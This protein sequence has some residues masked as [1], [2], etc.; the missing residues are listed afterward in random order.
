MARLFAEYGADVIRLESPQHPDLLRQLGGPSGLSPSFVS[1]NHSKRSF[2][3]DLSDPRGVEIARDLARRADVVVENLAPG[4][5]ERFGIGVDVL[6][7]ENPELVTV[8]SQ[9]MGN[10]GPWSTWRGYGANTQP[11]GGL[12]Y[13]WSYAD[14]DEPTG[15]NLAFPDHV[16]GRLGALAASACLLGDVTDRGHHVELVQAEVVINLLGDLFLR[17]SIRPSSVVDGESITRGGPV[18]GLSVQGCT[19]VVCDHLPG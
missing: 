11:P 16:A 2:G 8:S 12:T 13:L 1:S 9:M 18:G 3:V 5:L 7:D 10:R 14:R 17:E 4:A 6:H 15:S 19:A